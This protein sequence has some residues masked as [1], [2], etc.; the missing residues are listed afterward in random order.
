MSKPNSVSA[1]PV[2]NVKL[3]T[4]EIWDLAERLL[5]QIFGRLVLSSCEVDG[6]ELHL[7][8]ELLRDGEYALRARRQDDTVELE[9]HCGIDVEG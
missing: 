4:Y 7:H 2:A 5:L 6:D 8:V 3:R 9:N 1:E